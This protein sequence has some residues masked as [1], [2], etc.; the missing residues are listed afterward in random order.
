M[1]ICF[2]L[3]RILGGGLTNDMGVLFGLGRGSSLYVMMFFLLFVCITEIYTSRVLL[4]GIKNRDSLS[5]RYGQ[6][7]RIFWVLLG[8]SVQKSSIST[9]LALL[10]GCIVYVR[11][12]IL[13]DTQEAFALLTVLLTGWFISVLIAGFQILLFLLTSEDRTFMVITAAAFVYLLIRTRIPFHPFQNW[14]GIGLLVTAGVW[15]IV[16]AVCLVKIRTVF[17]RR[18]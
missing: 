16:L 4:F 5:V 17:I 13:W 9:G 11:G 7:G 6:R 10:A 12:E 18:Y 3:Q 1:I 2:T 15:G 8:K 14:P